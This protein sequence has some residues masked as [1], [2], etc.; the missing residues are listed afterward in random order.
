[1]TL[2]RIRNTALVGGGIAALAVGALLAGRLSAGALPGGRG[3][4][5]FAPRVFA[6]IARALE[7]SD[8]QKTRI[9]AV[10]K[11]H[12]AEIE[13][14]MR[15][16]SAARRALHQAVLTQPSDEAA[17]RAA[18]QQLGQVQG[19]G[20]VLFAK[21]RTEIQPI[22]TE[23][24]RAKI[25]QFRERARNHAESAVKSFEAFLESSS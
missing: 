16:S 15:S 25:Q 22:L 7:L 3:Q 10:L 12:A 9:K 4:G 24:Q 13:T 23:A 17:I 14:Q 21:I 18:A 2:Q 1:M 19:D 5:D 20:A 8:D 11:T 6:R